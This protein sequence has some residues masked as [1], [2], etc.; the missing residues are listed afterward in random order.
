MLVTDNFNRCGEED[1]VLTAECGVSVGQLLR[2]CKQRGLSGLEFLTGIP[3]KVGGLTFMNAGTKDGHVG[4][5]IESVTFLHGGKIQ[6][7][8]AKECCFAYKDTV[9]QRMPCVIL[10]VRF[11]LKQS[12][13]DEVAEN[14]ARTAQKRINLPK[15]KSMGCV[16]KN[17]ENGP[18]AGK[19]IEESGCKGWRMGGATVSPLHANFIVNENNATSKDFHVLIERIKRRVYERTGVVLHEEIRY[20]E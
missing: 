2:T 5:V 16:F 7:Y 14:I 1:G 11:R 18:S 13:P 8:T 6:T 15:G 19:L 10:S 12:T 20:I 3:A 4:D 9:F 17:P